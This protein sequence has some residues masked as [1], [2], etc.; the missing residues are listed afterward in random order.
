MY[1]LL[2]F[3]EWLEEDNEFVG[4]C[5]CFPSLSFLAPNRGD[6]LAGIKKVVRDVE[7]DIAGDSS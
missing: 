4:L 3:T 5:Q 7:A 1:E 2:C 6:A